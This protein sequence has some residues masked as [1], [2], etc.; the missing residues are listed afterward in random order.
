MIRLL[1]TFLFIAVTSNLNACDLCNFYSSINPYEKQNTVG[2]RYRYRLLQAE[3]THPAVR[4][5]HLDHGSAESEITRFD[6]SFNTYEAW[7][8]WYPASKIQLYVSVPFCDNY[9]YIN[10][11]ADMHINGIGDILITGQYEIYNST[12]AETEG[13][14][15]R[16][17]AGGGFK[18]PTG[19]Y[20]VTDQE[21]FNE[22]MQ[23]GSGSYDALAMITWVGKCNKA[24]LDLNGSYKINTA[25]DNDFRFANR[26]NAAASISYEVKTGKISLLPNA[27]VYFEAAE[28]DESDNVLIDDSGGQIWFATAGL[29]MS[30]KKLVLS[31]GIQ[32]PFSE[33]LNGSQTENIIRFQAGLGWLF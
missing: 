11:E 31:S 16:L 23:P 21:K 32:L 18:I 6:E 29:E 1:V 15:H 27:G 9:S 10:S 5:S 28:K 25:N 3:T 33:S 30:L 19:K 7:F 13:F 12:S 2:L 20:E 14:N 8:R 24:G 17:S 26:F 22:H 4:L